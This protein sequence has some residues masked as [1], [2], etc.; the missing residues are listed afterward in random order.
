MNAGKYAPEILETG[1]LVTRPLP[2]VNRVFAVGLSVMAFIDAASRLDRLDI[3][4]IRPLHTD[5]AAS[6]DDAVCPEAEV[7][8]EIN[9]ADIAGKTPSEIDAIARAAGLIPK[10][11][12]PAEGRGSYIDPVTGNQ[13]I[14]IHTNP[15]TGDA[16]AHVNNPAEERLDIN[17]NV[18]DND[19][20]D[21]H[22]PLTLP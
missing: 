4:P 5:S 21:A 10:G 16:H 2:P 14:L 17:G 13:R 12:N 7:S 18:V 20:P 1:A 19:A 15:K 22:L 3:H 11:K 6:G 9:P 8:P